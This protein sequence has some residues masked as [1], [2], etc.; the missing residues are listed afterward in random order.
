ME[1]S[2]VLKI[3]YDS[4]GELFSICFD[5]P[6]ED[7]SRNFNNRAG[8]TAIPTNDSI[9]KTRDF[10]RL[11]FIN[12][13][14]LLY[15]HVDVKEDESFLFEINRRAQLRPTIISSVRCFG[16][17]P[18]L[19]FEFSTSPPGSYRL[20]YSSVF[21]DY[22]KV[23]SSNHKNPEKWMY[24]DLNTGELVDFYDPFKGMNV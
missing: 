11:R 6:H 5:Y 24:H 9:N 23:S 3:S 15:N 18:I 7:V 12:V 14:G 20:A 21:V 22:R 1:E 2:L 19:A 8:K 13:S 17:R 10:R 4:E 16:S